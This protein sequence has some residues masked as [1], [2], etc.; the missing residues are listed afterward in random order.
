MMFAWLL[1]A[2]KHRFFLIH[3]A[4]RTFMPRPLVATIDISALRH[5]LAVARR[6]AGS[7]KVWAVVKADAY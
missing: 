5:N 4:L 2:G 7:A 3:F 1:R 6:H